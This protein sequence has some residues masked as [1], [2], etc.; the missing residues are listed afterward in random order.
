MNISN[1]KTAIDQLTA[2][3]RAWQKVGIF[4]TITAFFMAALLLVIGKGSEKTILVPPVV[5]KTFWVDGNKVAPEYI[6]QMAVYF[7]QL[8]L[9]ANP[10]N[11]DYQYNLLLQHVTPRAYGELKAELAVAADRLKKDNASQAFYPSE[12]VV[13]KNTAT[14]KGRLVKTVGQKVTSDD[15]VVYV[16]KFSYEGGRLYVSSFKHEDANAVVDE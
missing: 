15:T 12:V 11:V 9:N 16:I 6:E 1:H 5:S 4:S 2:D 10:A 7:A 8:A 3:K 13:L 14:M